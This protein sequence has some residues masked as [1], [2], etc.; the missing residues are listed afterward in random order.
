MN[1]RTKSLPLP[2][3]QVG[4]TLAEDLLTPRGRVV[5]PKDSVL[6]AEA[7]VG[8]ARYE[9]EKVTVL[10][11]DEAAA[12]EQ[13]LEAARHRDRIE[14]LFRNS[15]DGQASGLLRQYVSAYRLGE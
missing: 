11:S 14:R 7:I 8:L 2:E 9:V 3:L 15:G 5:L 12:A 10:L 13:A 1:Q 4:M 6:T